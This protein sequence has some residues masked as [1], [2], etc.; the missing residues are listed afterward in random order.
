MSHYDL[1][2]VG[3]DGIGPEIT[4]ET[5]RVVRAAADTVGIALDTVDLDAS[6]VRWMRTGVALPDDQLAACLAA[7]AVY[8]GAI[9]LPEARHPDGREVNGDVIL[10]LRTGLDLYAGL[11]P[12]RSFAGV[13]KVLTTAADIDYVVVRENV[14]GMFASRL[15]G[16]R[17]GD[18]VVTDTLIIT[19]YGTERVVRRA[20]ELART[21][22]LRT[23]DRPARVTCV[24]KSNAFASYAFFRAVFDDVAAEY[25][26]VERDYAYIDAMTTY[27]VQR[28]ER[29]DVVV[30]ENLFGDIISDLAGAT[31]GGLGLAPSADVGDEH[32][33]FQSAHGS[34]PDI[35]GLGI[36]NPTAAILSGA[37]MLSWLGAQHDDAAA[38]AAGERVERAIASVLADPALRTPDLG[39]PQTTEGFGDAVLRAVE[40]DA[41]AA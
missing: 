3:G 30:T 22:H 32:G 20:F 40:A 24:D 26:D 4:R 10:G 25:P 23:P 38:L 37:L 34:A 8:L 19:R 18:A 36:A 6:A 21:R 9:G 14:E 2:V 12:A 11:R 17:V 41:A 7:D 28:P 29:F 27:Q 13:P 33:M 1:A 5:I 16:A 39:G 15:G 31:V 35:A